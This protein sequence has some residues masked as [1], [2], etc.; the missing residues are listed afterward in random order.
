VIFSQ[1]TWKQPITNI[2]FRRSVRLWRTGRHLMPRTMRDL[3]HRCSVRLGRTGLT[4][5]RAKCATYGMAVVST[6]G[7]T[8]A[9]GARGQT[10]RRA[11]GATYGM[12]VISTTG[13]TC[14]FGARGQT[15]RRAQCATYSTEVVSTTGVTCAFGARGQT[16]R[17]AQ[18]ATYRGGINH[19]RSVRLWRTGTNPSSR[20]MRDL[21]TRF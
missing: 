15:H 1:N 9:F 7:V 11:K 18:C 17:R 20:T 13:V 19:R 10:H 14:A 5:C 21:L 8:C 2:K 12:A 4:Q 6:T 3:H 16:H